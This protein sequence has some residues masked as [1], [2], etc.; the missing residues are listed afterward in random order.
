MTFIDAVILALAL[1]AAVAGIMGLIA[2]I[3]DSRSIRRTL[4]HIERWMERH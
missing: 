3:L 1:L 2:S 4:Q